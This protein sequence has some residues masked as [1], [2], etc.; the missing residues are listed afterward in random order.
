MPPSCYN[1]CMVGDGTG[2]KRE[3]RIKMD[4]KRRELLARIV[5][6]D[7]ISVLLAR[8][9][10][11]AADSETAIDAEHEILNIIEERLEIDLDD[12]KGPHKDFL[13]HATSKERLTYAIDLH[14]A[15]NFK[16][17]QNLQSKSN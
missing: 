3:E 5:I 11:N 12:P 15:E 13:L 4:N 14:S 2:P 7:Q 10:A 16:Y 6:N 17:V 8:I 9:H 1:N